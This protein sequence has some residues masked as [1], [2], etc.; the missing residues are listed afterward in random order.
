MFAIAGLVDVPDAWW[1]AVRSA[2]PTTQLLAIPCK[3]ERDKL[4]KP[5]YAI[6]AFPRRLIASS[7]GRSLS[8]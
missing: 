8:Q 1:H 2:V 6:R 5:L 4:R 7:S 3:E